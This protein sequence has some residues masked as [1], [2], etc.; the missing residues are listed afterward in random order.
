MLIMKKYIETD[1]CMMA[2]A[3]DKQKDSLKEYMKK[4]K[5]IKLRVPE[6]YLQPIK[7]H[8]KAKGMSVNQ[9]VISLLEKD[10]GIE[11][12]TVRE[13][14]EQNKENENE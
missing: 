5:D 6:E 10:M 2:S 3:T 4:I 14:N 9:L 12:V 8:A 1:G 7:E 13:Q 11:I